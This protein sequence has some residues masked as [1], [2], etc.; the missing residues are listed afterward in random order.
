MVAHSRPEWWQ[1][2]AVL[3]GVG[4]AVVA[5]I[6]ALVLVL[7]GGE[8]EQPELAT[9]DVTDEATPTAGPT[10]STPIS[11]DFSPPAAP[12]TSTVVA[13]PDFLTATLTDLQDRLPPAS[14][15]Q[16]GPGWTQVPPAP[17][18]ARESAV[19]VWTGDEVIVWG[20]RADETFGDGA[21][22]DPEAGAWRELP[23]API[24]ARSGA[25]AA[26]TGVEMIVLGGVDMAQ[27]PLF[28][29][30]AYD[31]AADSWRVI[32]S[33]FAATAFATAMVWTGNELFITGV[34]P[35]EGGDEAA[36]TWSYVPAADS[37]EPLEANPR[38]GEA[39]GR[40]AFMTEAGLFVIQ[41][42]QG[43]DEVFVDWFDVVEPRWVLNDPLPGLG[44]FDVGVDD[45]VWT[46]SQFVFVTHYSD[47]LVYDPASGAVE[48]IPGSRS[49]TRWDAVLVDG[50]AFVGDLRFDPV[51]REWR[52]DVAYP[53]PD[54]EFPIVV[55]MDDMAFYW[56]GNGCGRASDCA[57]FVG[58]DE[59]LIWGEPF[60]GADSAMPELTCTNGE[61]E[62]VEYGD[63]AS[64]EAFDTPDEAVDVWWVT[65]DGAQRADREQLEEQWSSRFVTYV[66]AEATP[67][68]VLR[69]DIA[70]DQWSIV[71]AT[72]CPSF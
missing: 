16:P 35:N 29:G 25:V 50:H 32:E 65:G 68:L 48:P 3:A 14:I 60:A 23:E 53:H 62:T 36:D 56:G 43:E 69:L 63:A 54:R 71:A 9:V 51:G 40:R 18:E 2:P 4:L 44:A 27:Q 42:D 45:A 1:R 37:F 22:Y 38:P 34:T 67:Q 21:A 58:V 6:V 57:G 13:F 15:S 11:G 61:P 31:P 55:L 47:G 28:D 5:G 24:S 64:L 70:A 8:S 41:F 7:S 52:T 33:N 72:G 30:A 66:D 20:G 19:G 59:G 17:I 12:I 39:T 49:T 46:G 10:A 26:W